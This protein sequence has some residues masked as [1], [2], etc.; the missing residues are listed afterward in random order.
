MLRQRNWKLE[1]GDREGYVGPEPGAVGQGVGGAAVD[2]QYLDK[3]KQP[4]RYTQRLLM[5]SPTGVRST[6]L[7]AARH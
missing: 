6:V 1:Q 3:P 5:T 2:T 4:A 7:T